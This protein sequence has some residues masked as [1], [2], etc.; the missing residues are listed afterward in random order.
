[1]ADIVRV[2][3]LFD[4]CAALPAPERIDYLKRVCGDDAELCAEVASL[5]ACDDTQVDPLAESVAASAASHFDSAKPWLGRRVGSYRIVNELGRGGM[6][7]VYLAERAD[8]EYENRVAIK[9]IRGFP[10]SEALDRLRRERQVLAGLV[11]PNI[12]RLLDGGSTDEGQPFLV[13][14]FV[15]GVPL[16]RWTEKEQPSLQRRLRLFQQLCLAVHH[17]HQNL[18]IHRDLKPANV[19]V[20]ADG[21]PV[22]LDFGIAKLVSTG[23]MDERV[24]SLRAFTED[25]AS[26]EQLAGGTVTTASDIFALGLILYELLCG[27]R[28][29]IHLISNGA[30]TGRPSRVAAASERTWLRRDAKTIAGDLDHIVRRAL[31]EEPQHRYSSAAALA[32]D[33]ERFFNGEAL[34]AGPNRLGYRVRKFVRRH[35]A[36]VAAGGLALIAIVAASTWLAIERQRA[37]HAEHQATIEAQ[38]AEQVTNFLL[39]LFRSAAPESTRGHDTTA[40]ELLDNGRMSLNESL[41][42]QPQVRGRLMSA[43]GEIYTSIGQPQRS[44]ELLDQAVAIF[45]STNADPLRL[46]VALNESCRAY[47]AQSD[48]VRAALAC[49]EAL[50]IRLANLRADHPDIGHTY[51]ALGVVEQSQGDMSAA[52]ADYRRALEIFSD[53]GPE[54]R[55]G[56]ASAHHDLGFLAAH[57]GDY[58]TA[59]KEY[60]I[61][62]DMKH[63]LFGDAHPST[64]NSLN[65]LAQTEQALGDFDASRRDFEDVLRLRIRVHGIESNPV[66]HTH[67]DLA[68]LMQDMGDYAGAEQH[69]RDAYDLHNRLLAPDS[70]DLATT[71]NNLGTLFEDRG[72]FAAAIPMFERSL[73]IRS[74]KFKP[75]HPSLARAQ[76]NLARCLFEMG[77]VDEAEPLLTEAL[78]ARRALQ[79]MPAERFDSELLAADIALATRDPAAASALRALNPPNGA[80]NYRRRARY[81]DSLARAAAGR[82]DFVEAR[83]DAERALLALREKLPPDHPLCAQAAVRESDYAIKLSDNEAARRLLVSALPVLRRELVATAPDRRSAEA[84]AQ[85]LDISI[86]TKSAAR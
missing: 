59:L 72:D 7:S 13:I 2:R 75:P 11:H 84:L 54:Q 68:A 80:G 16:S 40:R 19:M 8:R 25:Y 49:R 31:S 14:E 62:Y 65:G 69:Y 15:D 57:A 24:T 21:T 3:E 51:E 61:A 83:E 66:A 60:R 26:P 63:T 1:M 46:A 6:G 67:N 17:A 33:V 64:L 43:L 53:G 20:R 50:S 41:A 86:E 76:H 22:L 32:N 55:E 5:L 81:A 28:Y 37:L 29:K 58:T 74:A 82:G 27:E 70:M 39:G 48:Y 79:T 71:A 23:P 34:E 85:S 77:K 35:R 18:I 45:R 42:D 73:Q 78:T 30:R 10:T 52:E 36:A 44:I 9:L 38:S 56:A 12:A 47:T 4:R